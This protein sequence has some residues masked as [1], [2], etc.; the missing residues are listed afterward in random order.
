MTWFV[1][2]RV[3]FVAAVA[4][5][6]SLVKPVHDLALVNV[7]FGA[8]LAGLV[9][10]FETQLR[11]TSVSA[12]LGAVLGGTIGLSL[13]KT[14]TTTLFWANTADSRVAFL[15]TVTLLALTYLGLVVGGRKG[16]W[17]EPA[18]LISLFRATAPE[19]ALQD[20]RHQRHHRRPHR[21]HLRD[22]LPRR[23]AGDSRSS[24]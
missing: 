6:A 16:E 12:M 9:V 7:L 19:E 21:R 22:G 24:C 17:L 11:D 4:Y 13:A 10:V 18:R 20:P 15:H 3:L 2:A 23:H 8:G 14:V 1:F 5:S